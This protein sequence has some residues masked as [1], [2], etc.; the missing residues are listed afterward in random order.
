MSPEMLMPLDK[1]F[2]RV[3]HNSTT[4]GL[5]CDTE[6]ALV[7]YPQTKTD[8]IQLYLNSGHFPKSFSET[9]SYSQNK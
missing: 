3:V 9:F 5:Y 1:M 2:K 8:Y 7:N 4:R 6:G